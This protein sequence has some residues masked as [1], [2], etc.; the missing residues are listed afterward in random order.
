MQFQ[1]QAEATV[2]ERKLAPPPA[3]KKKNTA[4]IAA[5]AAVVVL[6]IAI[7]AF[8]AL[9]KPDAAPVAT[10]TTPAGTEVTT[11]ASGLAAGQGLL[12]LSASPWGDLDRIVSKADQKEVTLPADTLSTPARIA[13]EPGSYTVTLNG[14]GAPKTIEVQIE[15]GKPTARHVPM[16][17]VD[18]DTLTREVTRP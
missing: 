2:L 3:E 5:I 17:D 10:T 14:P 8:I 9:K 6:A 4:M 16:A 13:L 18:F 7:G 11:T 12:L 15:A 1:G